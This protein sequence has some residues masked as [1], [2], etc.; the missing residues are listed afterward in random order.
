M[1]RLLFVGSHEG[2]PACMLF[3]PMY[4]QC[5]GMK[6]RIRALII[7]QVGYKYDICLLVIAHPGPFPLSPGEVLLGP[8]TACIW[9]ASFP[10]AFVKGALS[11]CDLPIL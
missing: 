9:M 6:R 10:W 1:F 2:R 3:L 5:P 11:Q 8:R 4:K 7:E